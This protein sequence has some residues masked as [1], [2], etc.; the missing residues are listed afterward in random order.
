MYN[1]NVLF[2]SRQGVE[3]ANVD[4]EKNI[5]DLEGYLRHLDDQCQ[6]GY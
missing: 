5:T 1:N 4:M 6:Q 3:D 2:Y